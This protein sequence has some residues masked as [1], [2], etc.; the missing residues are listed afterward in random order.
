MTDTLPPAPP[1]PDDLPPQPP[2]LWN[3]NTLSWQIAPPPVTPPPAGL[4]WGHN[5]TPEAKPASHAAAVVN[6]IAG[7]GMFLS[8]FLPAFAVT[9][10]YGNALWYSMTQT[11]DAPF[12]MIVGLGIAALGAARIHNDNTGI[13]VLVALAGVAAVI[14]A[15]TDAN[16]SHLAF[17]SAVG[18]SGYGYTFGAAL[19]LIGACGVVAAASCF[20]PKADGTGA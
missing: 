1:A 15:V 4:D 5:P 8:V 20:M 6:I 19:F 17:L 7:A 9:D 2:L 13:C 11:P 16:R 10:V 3:P 12:F 18:S 14:F